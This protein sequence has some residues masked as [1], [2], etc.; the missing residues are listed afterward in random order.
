MITTKCAEVPKLSKYGQHMTFLFIYQG[1]ILK[2]PIKCNPTINLKIRAIHHSQRTKI[3]SK[4]HKTNFIYNTN[5]SCMTEIKYK[6]DNHTTYVYTKL[7]TKQTIPLMIGQNSQ[8]H[9]DGS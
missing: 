6:D 1:S 8:D 5:V 3:L 9:S 2:I 4:T 7:P